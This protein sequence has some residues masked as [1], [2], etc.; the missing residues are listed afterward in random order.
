MDREKIV[1]EIVEDIVRSRKG[2]IYDEEILYD[3]VDAY[4]KAESSIIRNKVDNMM[5]HFLDEDNLYIKGK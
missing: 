5:K 2:Q 3:F 1:K 4:F